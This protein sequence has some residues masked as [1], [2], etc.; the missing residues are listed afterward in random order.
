MKIETLRRLL[1]RVVELRSTSHWGLLAVCSLGSLVLHEIS[2]TM[3]L[4][5]YIYIVKSVYA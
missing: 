1:V 3:W 5:L 4:W 2:K